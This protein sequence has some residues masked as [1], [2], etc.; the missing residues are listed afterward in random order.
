MYAQCIYDV[1]FLINIHISYI[2]IHSK[3]IYSIYFDHIDKLDDDEYIYII[4]FV[5]CFFFYHNKFLFYNC[6]LGQG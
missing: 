2:H 1:Y 3:C 6:L 5:F 4:N